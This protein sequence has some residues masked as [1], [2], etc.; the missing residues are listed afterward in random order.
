MHLPK[1]H[2]IFFSPKNYYICHKSPKSKHSSKVQ[3][4]EKIITVK[5][6]FVITS[7]L[8]TLVDVALEMRVI[9]YGRAHIP[10]ACTGRLRGRGES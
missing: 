4:P 6:L 7:H 3:V 1:S 2:L 5:Y 10:R 8:R 9:M